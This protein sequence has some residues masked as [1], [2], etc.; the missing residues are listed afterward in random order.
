M[1]FDLLRDQTFDQYI[2]TVIHWRCQAVNMANYVLGIDI[3]T[4]SVKVV[5]LDISSRTVTHSFSTPTKADIVSEE[6]H[7]NEQLTGQIITTMNEC[8]ASLPKDK[9][10]NVSRIGVSGQM[11]GV[12]FWKA[13]TGCDWISGDNCQFFRTRDSSQLITWQ[14]GRCHRDFL[15]ALPKPESHLNVATGFGCATIFW[16]MRHRPGFLSNFTVAGTIHDYVVSM[17]CGLERCAMTV[18]NA[19]SWGYFNTATNQWNIDILTDA[20]FPVH[21]LPECVPSGCIAGQ[22]CCEWHG[23]PANT[24]V[25]AALGD[26]Q[27]SV[28]S[29]MT[30]RTDAVLNISTSAQLIYAMPLDFTPPNY[31]DPTST[32]SYF[33]YFDGSYLAVAASLNGGNVMASLVGMLSGWISD[34][35][36]ELSDSSL[37]ET[38]IRCALGVDNSDLRVSPTILGERHDP[39]SLGRVSNIHPSNLSLGHMTRAVCRGILDNITVMMHPLFLLEA[40][41]QRIMGSGSALSRNAVLRQEAERAFPL[42]VVYGQDVDSAVGVALVFHDRL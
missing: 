4:T 22:T 20:G 17:L 27:C 28:Y 8:I 3:G 23:V 41:V 42:P 40:G 25:G 39:L 6:M 26:L 31:A 34:L 18:Q 14:D 12:V 16:Y 30:D 21:L 9:L 15:S 13:Q 38:L 2:K 32:I 29:S 24:P 35:G 33:P 10:K 19:A 5:L 11:H 37:Y 36:L 1:T 7:A